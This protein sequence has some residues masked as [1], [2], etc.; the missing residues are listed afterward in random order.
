MKVFVK[1]YLTYKN[2]IG[3][4]VL[5]FEPAISLDE[6]ITA[7]VAKQ[8]KGFE[9]SIL[10]PASGQISRQA[11]V[12]INGCHYTHLPEGVNTILKDGDQ[13]AIFP[14]IAGGSQ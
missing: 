3:E 14:P 2:L 7:L 8:G 4:Q 10:D 6:L 9:T 11:A 1:G 5:E 13:V 12:L